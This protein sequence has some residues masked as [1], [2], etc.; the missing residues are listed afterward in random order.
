M[1]HIFKSYGEPLSDADRANLD[2]MHARLQS[3]LDAL[4]TAYS[5]WDTLSA[6]QKDT[7]QRQ[8]L[9]V[10]AALIQLE[11]RSYVDAPV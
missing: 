11:L 10:L 6:A 8:S 2:L 5:N 4:R 1:S 3:T 9:R 7:A